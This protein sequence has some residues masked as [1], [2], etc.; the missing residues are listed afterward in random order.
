MVSFSANISLALASA[1][2]RISG[3]IRASSSLKL[4]AIIV[5]LLPSE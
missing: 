3:G 1:R 4:R 5:L 2:A